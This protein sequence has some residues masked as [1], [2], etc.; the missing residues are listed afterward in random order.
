VTLT[1]E[2]SS[3]DRSVG[4]CHR[5]RALR[6]VSGAAA[7]GSGRGDG[8]RWRCPRHLAPPRRVRSARAT[9]GAGVLAD[10]SFLRG[11][12]RWTASDPARTSGPPFRGAVL[13]DL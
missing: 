7:N 12:S 11:W 6:R 8:G 4:P 9:P 5:R 3:P 13:A 1:G 2:R 10:L